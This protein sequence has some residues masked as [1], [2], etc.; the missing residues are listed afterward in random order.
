MQ[1]TTA[2]FYDH[3]RN[4]VD[5]ATGSAIATVRRELKAESNCYR[6]EANWAGKDR[7]YWDGGWYDAIGLAKDLVF[8]GAENVV[9]TRPNGT[10]MSVEEIRSA[11]Y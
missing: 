8:N 7:F 3:A 9:M 11:R 10:V 4:H 6:V 5:A 1:T 2:K